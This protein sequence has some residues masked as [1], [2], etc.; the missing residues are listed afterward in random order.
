MKLTLDERVEQAL[1]YMRPDD[2]DLM[3]RLLYRHGEPGSL[4]V[5]DIVA[6]G[7]LEK[8]FQRTAP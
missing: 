6:R 1:H 7:F 5:E 4:I 2:A 3:D 8:H